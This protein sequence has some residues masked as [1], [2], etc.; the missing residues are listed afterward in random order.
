[1]GVACKSLGFGADIYRG[2][3]D[4]KYSGQTATETKPSE[5]EV[6]VSACAPALPEQPKGLPELSPQHPRWNA[7]I[8]WAAKKPK[9]KPSWTLKSAI[10][11]QWNITDANF[12][13]LMRLSGRQTSNN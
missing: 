5:K 11:K 1:M 10:R 8:S 6:T 4:T 13:E 7:F 12:N 9:D 3:N 2:R